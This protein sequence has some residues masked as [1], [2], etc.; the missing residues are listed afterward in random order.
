MTKEQIVQEIEDYM[1][2]VIWANDYFC[3]YNSILDGGQKYYEEVCLANSFFTI[4]RYSLISSMLMEIVKLFDSREEK[5]LSKLIE[6]CIQHRDVFPICTYYALWKDDLN[7]NDVDAL[8]ALAKKEIG[9]LEPLVLSLKTRRDK[10]YAHNDKK[11]FSPSS[12]LSDDCPIIENDVKSLLRYAAELCN[13]L[14][15]ALTETY[16]YPK[17][18]DSDDLLKLLMCAHRKLQK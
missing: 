18:I 10:Y 11:Y 2:H 15:K 3:A 5:C 4:T 16:I 7:V 14:L 12:N 6:L 1:H 17:H 8:L 9:N 13:S